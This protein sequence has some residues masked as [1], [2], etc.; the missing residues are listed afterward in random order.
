MTGANIRKRAQQN[1]HKNDAAGANNA[2]RLGIWRNDQKP[3]I[4]Q[5][6][7][8]CRKQRHGKHALAAVFFLQIWSNQQQIYEIVDQM[9]PT[10]VTNGIGK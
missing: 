6:G 7:Y 1:H 9:F 4:Q 3:Q 5:T 10:A 2:R 8:H